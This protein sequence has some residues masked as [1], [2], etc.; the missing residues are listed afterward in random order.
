MDQTEDSVETAGNKAQHAIGNW[1]GLAYQKSEP[2]LEQ[3]EQVVPG[4][5]PEPLWYTKP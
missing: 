2:H 3:W 5:C 1:R 4:V